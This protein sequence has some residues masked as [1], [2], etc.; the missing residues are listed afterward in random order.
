MAITSSADWEFSLAALPDRYELVLPRRVI[1]GWGRRSELGALAAGIGRRAFLF[2]GRRGPNRNPALAEIVA[3]LNAAG[4]TLAAKFEVAREPTVDDIDQAVAELREFRPAVSDHSAAGDVA[5]A[6]GGGSTIDFAKAVCALATQTDRASVRDYLEGVGRGLKIFQPPLAWIAVPTTGGTGAEATK[7]AVISVTNPSVKKSLRS[8]VMM[9][10]AV[11]IDPALSLGVPADVTT[12]TG[13]DA[14]T[15]LFESYISRNRRPVP[16]ALALDGLRR[17][18]PALPDAVKDGMNRPAREAMAHAAFLSGVALA[19]SGLGMAHGVAAA[20]GAIA[21]VPH[22]LACAVMAPVALAANRAT[23]EK[24]LAEL[25]RL[26]L[27]VESSSE[28]AAANAFIERV[29]SLCHELNVPTRLA[30]LGI[31]R[32]DIPALVEQSWGN[33]MNGNPRE[34]TPQELTATLEAMA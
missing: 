15:Q 11:V 17:A 26:T 28:A 10:A 8:D 6:V 33:S 14:I 18:I 30:D 1:F 23:S 19:N 31:A 16:Q 27:G 20:L 24:E 22:G 7:N 25:G 4:V 5:I 34:I 13:L 29:Q 9:A 32:R 2:H 21:N 3:N 12:W